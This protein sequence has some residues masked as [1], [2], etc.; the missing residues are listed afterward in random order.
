MRRGGW[1]RTTAALAC[2]VVSV[3]SAGTAAAVAR[4]S[5]APR[6][7]SAAISYAAAT[8]GPVAAPVSVR[9]P[10]IDVDAEL[11]ELG[12]DADGALEVPPYEKAGW[13]I[14]GPRPGEEGAAVI[15][16]HVDSRTGPAVF[17]RLRK[18]QPGDGVSVAYDDGSSVTFEVTRSES[19]PKSNFPTAR[20]YGPTSGPEL[21]LITCD[22]TFDRRSGSYSDNLIV[23]AAPAPSG[24]PEPPPGDPSATLAH[25]SSPSTRPT[26]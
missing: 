9:I 26:T 11:V 5:S 15:A 6:P 12:L 18:L 7:P 13:F 20:V 10:A 19:F 14:G 21:R 22:G 25:V 24:D 1:D 2:L 4:R 3:G 23:W 8:A 16:A 17:Y